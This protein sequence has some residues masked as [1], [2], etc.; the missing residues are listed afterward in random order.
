MNQTFFL[1]LPNKLSVR[2]SL[3]DKGLEVSWSRGLLKKDIPDLEQYYTPWRDNILREWSIRNDT[4]ID[5]ID[6]P[7]IELSLRGKL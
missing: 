1:I 5:F 6:F 3:S 2:F 7:M 4:R